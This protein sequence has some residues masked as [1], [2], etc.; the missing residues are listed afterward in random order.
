MK[1]LAV[2]IC[3]AL[4]GLCGCHAKVTGSLDVDGSDFA[5]KQ[6]RS[7]QA[8]G[9]TGIELTD[10]DGRR[11]RLVSKV[12]GTCEAA[13]FSGDSKTGDR[14]GQCGVLTVETQSSRINEIYNVRGSAKLSCESGPHKV[15]GNV[16]F[17]NCH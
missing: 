17:E 1:K 8:F 16:E 11:L 15:S 4:G 5:I 13:L 10:A 3:L 7:G 12:E 6:C 14:L 9:Y 2:F